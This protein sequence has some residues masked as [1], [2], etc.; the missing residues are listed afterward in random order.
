ME[1]M[2]MR[3]GVLVEREFEDLE[4]WYPLLRMKEAGAETVVIGLGWP[5]YK[6]KHGTEIKPDCTP[7]EISADS[8]DGLIVPGGWAPDRLRRDAGVLLL[9]RSVFEQEKVV[10]SICHGPWV[11]TSARICKGRRLTGVI[12]IKD[13]IEFAGATYIDQE[14]VVDGNLVTS[15]HPLDIPAWAREIVKALAAQKRR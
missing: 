15:R 3:I 5:S 2:G 4:L 9:V 13:D 6:G 10:A 11:L 8:L 1:L 12:A 14:V 7:K